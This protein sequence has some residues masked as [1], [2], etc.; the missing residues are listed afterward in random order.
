M[1]FGDFLFFYLFYLLNRYSQLRIEST[2]PIPSIAFRANIPT[3]KSQEI[4]WAPAGFES[5][6]K[7]VMLSDAPH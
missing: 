1:H 4:F 3:T 5:I 6:E 2:R 7:S